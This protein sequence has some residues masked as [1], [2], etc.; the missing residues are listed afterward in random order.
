L[1]CTI[2]ERATS[3]APSSQY[4]TILEQNDRSAE[5]HNNL[6]VLYQDAGRL[7]DAVAEFQRALAIDPRHV[8]ARS[9]MGV[10]LL[11]S[12]RIDQAAA[13]LRQAM[14]SD[15]RNVE[16]IV[17]FALVQRALGRSIDART[18][19]LRALTLDPGMPARTTTSPSWLT[20]AA[21]GR[22]P[23]NTTA[24]SCGTAPRRDLVVRVRARLAALGG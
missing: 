19:L 21:S 14:T 16:A 9:N 17:N 2:S 1:P 3:T 20:K 4:R 23:S 6:G 13:E 5:A 18:L 12:N 7:D 24:P 11:Q 10:A 8:K 22:W 15:P